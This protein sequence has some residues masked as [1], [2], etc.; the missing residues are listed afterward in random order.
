MRLCNR[1]NIKVPSLVA[2]DRSLNL[3]LFIHPQCTN[4][5]HFVPTYID[6]FKTWQV[7]VLHSQTNVL[8]RI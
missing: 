4:K 6:G 2:D 8:T 7:A 3:D 5:T 1:R